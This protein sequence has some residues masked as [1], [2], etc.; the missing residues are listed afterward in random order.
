MADEPVPV[1]TGCCDSGQRWTPNDLSSSV[2]CE[3]IPGH[4]VPCWPFEYGN[5]TPDCIGS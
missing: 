2:P 4:M 5:W 1:I 3:A